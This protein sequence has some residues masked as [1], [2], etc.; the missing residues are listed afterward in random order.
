MT[1]VYM[2]IGLLGSGKSTWAKMFVK[3]HANTKIVSPDAFRAMLN[4]EYKYLP[5]L[6]YVISH[7]CYETADLLLTGKESPQRKSYDV[8]IDCGNQSH[9]RRCDWDSL[10]CDRR[11]AVV[12]P[13]K[14]DDWHVNNR[15][16]KP[17]WDEV[18]W[19]EIVKAERAAYEPPTEDEFDEI[20]HIEENR[21]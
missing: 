21:H 7:A 4:G 12:M 5:E 9:I 16:K 8:I 15:L 18:D 13:Q 6:D 14:S 10:P 11:I 3:K 19:Y 20:W 1:T 17:H 2:T